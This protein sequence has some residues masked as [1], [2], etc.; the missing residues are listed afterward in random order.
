MTS[1]DPDQIADQVRR[2][3]GVA[4]LSGGVTGE[5]ATYLP[6]RRVPGVRIS[7]DR[8]EV[9]LVVESRRPVHEVADAVRRALRPLVGSQ[10]VDVVVADISI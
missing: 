7:P 9:H 10:P 8:V 2:V 1:P 5:I 3:D 4:D 6:G